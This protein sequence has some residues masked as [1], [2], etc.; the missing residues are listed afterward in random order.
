MSVYPLYS[1]MSFVAEG[2]ANYGIDLAFP[3]DEAARFEQD[4]LLPLAG[5]TGAPVERKAELNALVRRLARAEYTIA[6]DYLAGRIDR[7]EA[8]QLLS[9]YMLTTP[10]RAAQRVRFIDTYR[11]YIIN[12]GLGRDVVQAWVERQGPDHW[13]GMETLLASQILP[14]DLF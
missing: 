4:V 7:A 9:R 12:Y 5:L 3:G 11:S 8:T 1:P 6:D 14:V 13:Q 10:E 2:S